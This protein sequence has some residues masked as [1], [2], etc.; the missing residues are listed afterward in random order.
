MAKKQ[1]EEVTK[2]PKKKTKS[3]SK[4]KRKISAKKQKKEKHRQRQESSDEQDT[5]DVEL[6]AGK[7]GVDLNKLRKR[8]KIKKDKQPS[9]FFDRD[10][11]MFKPA[12]YKGMRV[13]G[14]VWLAKI[15]PKMR[16]EIA[17]D[18][19]F[20]LEELAKVGLAR[21]KSNAI[22]FHVKSGGAQQIFT[23]TNDTDQAELKTKS[24]IFK[25]LY[26]FGM[27]VGPCQ[28]FGIKA[29]DLVS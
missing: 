2:A 21:R 23:C 1:L 18:V 25:V 4:K 12:P 5:D 14:L 17:S 28:G 19:F 29:F 8:K 24:E 3:K 7:F 22:S 13:E 16:D 6:L 10:G 20:P 26:L 11:A 9:E 15:S 27:Y